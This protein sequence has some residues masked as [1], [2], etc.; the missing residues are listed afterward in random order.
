MLQ[1]DI[2]ARVRKTFGKGAARSLRRK[3]WTPANL[4]GPKIDPMA[5]ELETKPLMKALLSVHRQIAVINLDIDEGG[6]TSKRYV[7]TKEVQTDPVQ[8]SLVH[9]DFYEVSLDVPMTL[10]VTVKYTGKSK[11]VE[12]GGEMHVAMK[13]VKLLGKALDLPDFIEV[14]ISSM[15]LGSSLTCKAMELPENVTLQEDENK[16]C[17]SISG[18]IEERTPVEETAP[19]EEEAAESEE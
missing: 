5:L 18:I 4:Y 12:L 1:L 13:T 19:A 14:D 6:K 8:D 15:G 10:P 11:G 16:V 7:M 2:T 17:V 3:G 9:A